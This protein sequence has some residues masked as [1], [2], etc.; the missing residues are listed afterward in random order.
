MIDYLI[1]QYKFRPRVRA[2]LQSWL[3]QFEYFEEKAL[4]FVINRWIDDAEGVTLD[5]WGRLLGIGRGTLEDDEYRPLVKNHLLLLKMSGTGESNY[6]LGLML[7]L[8]LRVKDYYPAAYVIEHLGFG[9][10]QRFF[11]VFR[12][13]RPAG[14]RGLFHWSFESPVDTFTMCGVEDYPTG[15][16]TQGFDEGAFSS[17]TEL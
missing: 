14:V 17:V 9:D 8:V 13:Q 11:F 3:N 10:I 15:P 4:E 2:I 6:F 5:V 1:E 7:G 16:V 12:R